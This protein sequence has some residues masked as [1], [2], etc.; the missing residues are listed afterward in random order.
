[1]GKLRNRIVGIS[2]TAA[3]MVAS[4]A[5]T[6]PQKYDLISNTTAS[7]ASEWTGYTS[8]GFIWQPS[9]YDYLLYLTAT[10]D[11]TAAVSGC[12]TWSTDCDIT[13]PET[14][15]YSNKTYT[16][17]SIADN[18]FKNQTNIKTVS[19][20]LNVTIIGASAFEGC[21]NLKFYNQTT[22]GRSG[23]IN[24]YRINHHAFYNCSN[25][26]DA[27]IWNATIIE[28][29]AFA[30]CTML[31]K[32]PYGAGNI[33]FYWHNLNTIGDY[34]FFR[35]ESLTEL[36][37]SGAYVPGI[38]K[39]AFAYCGLKKVTLPGCTTI[40]DYAFYSCTSLKYVKIPEG[41]RQI[42][43]GAFQCC[44]SLEKVLIPSSVYVIR[45]YVF[46]CCNA[47]KYAA[48]NS[49]ECQIGQH[50]FGY[51]FNNKMSD[52]VLYGCGNGTKNYADT[53]GVTYKTISSVSKE[54]IRTAAYKPYMWKFTNSHPF[55]AVSN[56]SN[57]APYY[58]AADTA[59]AAANG[60]TLSSQ[61]N[62]SCSGMSSLSIMAAMGRF[63]VNQFGNYTT[64]NSISNP[65]NTLIS[66]I[67][68]AQAAQN[69]Y[70]GV[71]VN[72]YNS[73]VMSNFEI[74]E[75]CRQTNYGGAP[76]RLIFYP[77]SHIQEG[78]AVVCYGYETATDAGRS[79]WTF[80][81]CPNTSFNA[82]IL[83]YDPNYISISANRHLY[84]NTYTGEYCM[85]MSTYGKALY[86]CNGKPR[87]MSSMEFAYQY[88]E[89]TSLP[90]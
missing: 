89:L 80:G 74:I 13:I 22:T 36:D 79:N 75:N 90:R 50:A 5:G 63:H 48:I 34:A 42:E 54:S 9:T 69:K 73:T 25:L 10:S 85:P 83:I 35:C 15:T 26:L 71:S 61:F 40:G 20:G 3:L 24:L 87:T 19:G 38:G 28:D 56:A 60:V 37:M 70:S 82:R 29:Y 81:Y 72:H 7:A 49:P 43:A 77:S 59:A 68:Y 78:H 45:P 1:M 62:G 16:V 33:G 64:P 6:L 31:G 86:F 4:F 67:N 46:N 53:Y 88:D 51:I 32:N 8:T 18:A 66:C 55:L 52:F 57:A 11:T 12:G 47:L 84:I 14:V 41:A 58:T 2:L 39:Y 76:V 23:D 17:T 21:S 27:S 44:S 30:N 65:S